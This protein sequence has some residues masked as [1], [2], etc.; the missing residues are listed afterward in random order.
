LANTH[1]EVL[2]ALMTHHISSLKDLPV[3]A[4]QFQNKFRNE[5][6]AK[7]G[8]LRTREFVMKDLYSFCRSVKEHEEFYEKAKKAYQKVFS[9][10]G[11]E[12]DTLLTFA[13]G[14][15]FSEYSH[16]FQTLSVAGEDTVYTCSKCHIAV[17]KE[18]VEEDPECPECNNKDLKEEKAIE[19]GNIFSLGTKYAE[20]LGL[21]F[22]DE[23]GARQPVVMGSYG[24]GPGRLMG[25]IVELLHDERG[26][27]W[28][29]SVAPF[30]THLLS[31]PGGEK[32]AEKLYQQLAG[33]G[34]EVLY[35]DRESSPGEKLVDADLFGI[36]L[37]IVVSEKTVAADCVEIKQRSEE[38][39]ELVQ[40]KNLLSRIS[41]TLLKNS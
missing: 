22:V 34:I 5:T 19:V 13:S 38:K 2:A 31:L 17:N 26:I 12:K 9:R 16:E 33:E 8:L 25:T 6:R 37:R 10:A 18:I 39:P 14:G 21:E 35:D 20:A 24:I 32:E 27:I 23:K 40:S 30:Q 28:P 4:Y 15:S 3:F 11:I 1:E 41:Q 29:Q 36:P 7:S